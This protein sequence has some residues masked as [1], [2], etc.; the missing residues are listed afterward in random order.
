[1]ALRT[2]N[3]EPLKP[4]HTVISL[5]LSRAFPSLTSKSAGSAPNSGRTGTTL[6][7]KALRRPERPDRRGAHA[8]VRAVDAAARTAPQRAAVVVYCGVRGSCRQDESKALRRSIRM[9]AHAH[10]NYIGPPD[11]QA[12]ACW[13]PNGVPYVTAACAVYGCGMR[14]VCD[15]QGAHPLD[16]VPHALQRADHSLGHL[17]GEAA[18]QAL[19]H[20]HVNAGVQVSDIDNPMVHGV[21]GGR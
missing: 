11:V 17:V 19:L 4:Q 14:Y 16:A 10:A 6:G 3:P 9:N 13:L 2:L 21:T 20:V 7:P 12:A 15:G 18:D 1:M 8:Y 5:T